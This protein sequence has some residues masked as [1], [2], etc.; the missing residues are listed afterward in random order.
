MRLLARVVYGCIDQLADKV[1]ETGII[2]VVYHIFYEPAMAVIVLF[3]P[4]IVRRGERDSVRQFPT[5]IYQRG[6]FSLQRVL[7]AR[8]HRRFFAMIPRRGQQPPPGHRANA[9]TPRRGQLSPQRGA[10]E[11]RRDPNK[12][13]VGQTFEA[14]EKDEIRQN[15]GSRSRT[16]VRQR[17]SRQTYYYK[18]LEFFRYKRTFKGP[19]PHGKG[20][21]ENVNGNL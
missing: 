13:D 7:Q 12:F 2:M 17:Q 21:R 9:N 11:K 19:R 15:D 8:Q 20:R 1:P 16:D 18:P 14:E 4:D 10:L 3:Y 6:M 5:H